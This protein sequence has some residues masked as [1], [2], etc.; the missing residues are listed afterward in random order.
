[1][2][3]SPGEAKFL[4][5]LIFSGLTLL[6][7]LG[8]VVFAVVAA[9][10]HKLKGM[11]ILAVG[12]VVGLLQAVVNFLI[13]SPFNL[14]DHETVMKYRLVWVAY[15]SFAAMFAALLGWCVLAFCRKK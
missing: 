13:S 4:S 2:N 11:W 12:A 15:L 9:R 8:I 1:M 10:R 3:V 14:V 6:M 5:F 7:Q